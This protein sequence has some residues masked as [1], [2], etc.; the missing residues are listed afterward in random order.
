MVAHLK[1]EPTRL[2]LLLEPAKPP[3]G[4]S[5]WHGWRLATRVVSRDVL[6]THARN[7]ADDDRGARIQ[8][9]IVR[10][11]LTD[12]TRSEIAHA[13]GVQS[14]IAQSYFNGTAWRAYARPV[15]RRLRE[16]GIST[17]GRGQWRGEATRPREIV[18]AAQRLMAHAADALDGQ[19][20]STAQRARLVSDLRLLGAVATDG[21]AP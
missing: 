15:L 20:L 14:R 6:T 3:A 9:A 18:A 11:L 8:W 10:Y 17:G 2:P 7:H 13:I 16:L 12:T 19:P 4:V 5:R 21:R 1:P